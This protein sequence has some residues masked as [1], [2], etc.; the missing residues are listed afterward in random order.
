MGQKASKYALGVVWMGK[1][2]QTL[3]DVLYSKAGFILKLVKQHLDA[4]TLFEH[5]LTL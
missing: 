5:L 4:F 3:D 1:S 2:I